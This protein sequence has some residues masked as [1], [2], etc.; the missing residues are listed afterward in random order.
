MG[1]ISAFEIPCPAGT[2]GAVLGLKDA[3]CSGICLQ[4]YDCPAGSVDKWGKQ[5]T[6]GLQEKG[7]HEDLDRDPREYG[8]GNSY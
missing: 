6:A 2:Y 3:S 7:D 4:G 8:Q 5:S 1:S